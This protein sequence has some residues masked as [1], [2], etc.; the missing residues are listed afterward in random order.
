MPISV[1]GQRHKSHEASPANLQLMALLDP[2]DLKKKSHPINQSNISGKRKGMVVLCNDYC[3]YVAS[4]SGAE[5]G[6]KKSSD[7]TDIH[8]IQEQLKDLEDAHEVLETAQEQLTEM[9]NQLDELHKELDADTKR[10]DAHL[11]GLTT[12]YETTSA[13]VDRAI[14]EK[15]SNIKDGA[16][17]LIFGDA[18][19]ETHVVGTRVQLSTMECLPT[20]YNQDKFN[21][22]RPFG[23][24][25]FYNFYDVTVPHSNGDDKLPVFSIHLADESGHQFGGNTYGLGFEMPG[26]PRMRMY[27][28]HIG[29]GG[30]L[31]TTKI[32]TGWEPPTPDEIGAAPASAVT[33]LSGH[34]TTLSTQVDGVAEDVNGII[35]TMDRFIEEDVPNGI[36]TFGNEE[37]DY[38]FRG[39]SL[40]VNT[41]FNW[42]SKYIPDPVTWKWHMSGMYTTD[43][44]TFNGH[45]LA[46]LMIHCARS[47]GS[48]S[49]RGI[50]FEQGAHGWGVYTTRFDEYGAYVGQKRIY[51]EA[52]PPSPIEVGAVPIE[53]FE[54]LKSELAE[55]KAMVAKLGGK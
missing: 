43:T 15:T 2:E 50:S 3:L 41:N 17:D 4:G 25:G 35:Q 5:D 24:S 27:A 19:E 38:V 34:I 16:T 22:G 30:R 31:F 26:G 21:A 36:V 13:L 10:I 54:A 49:S 47:T 37:D 46:P 55:L 52:N 42:R 20:V 51:T 29:G 8:I 39:K 23:Y 14:N 11:S 53:E 6:W 28:Y 9:H 32:Y 1:T 7:V 33:E 48:G 45:P 12:H 44:T 40:Q 18:E